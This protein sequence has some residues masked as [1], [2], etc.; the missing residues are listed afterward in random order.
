MEPDVAYNSDIP[1]SETPEANAAESINFIPDSLDIRFVWFQRPLMQQQVK[2]K[3]PIQ[4][5]TL[6]NHQLRS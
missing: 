4:Y 2:L 3:A 6:K 1:N 5:R